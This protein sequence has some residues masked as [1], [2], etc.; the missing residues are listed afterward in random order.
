MLGWS[1]VPYYQHDLNAMREAEM[2][3][4]DVPPPVTPENPNPK[5]ERTRYREQLCVVCCMAGG[6]IHATAAQRSE[7]FLKVKGRWEDS[8]EQ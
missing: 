4:S 6:P 8:D 7:A 3:L 1:L 2:T 5:S